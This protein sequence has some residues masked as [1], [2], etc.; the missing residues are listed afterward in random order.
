M[1]QLGL[2]TPGGRGALRFLLTAT[3]TACSG[4][5]SDTNDSGLRDG[6]APTDM[7]A[8]DDASP[9]PAPG[10]W[11][12][13]EDHYVP[14]KMAMTLV[15]PRAAD[16]APW[17]YGR[18]AHPGVRWEIPIVVQGGAWP[19]RYEIVD[20][21]GAAGLE[22][23][24]E[25]DRV[26]VDGFVVHRVTEAYGVLSWDAPVAGDY[27]IELRVTDQEGST[28]AVDVPLTVGAE[29]WLFVDAEA[30]D[31]DGDGSLEAPFASVERIHEGGDAFA[32]HRVYVRGVVP[33]DG[34]RDNGNLRI[35]T[36]TPAPAVW[37]GFPGSDAVLEAYEGKIVLDRPDFYLA[38]LEHRHRE[39]FFQAD[40]TYLHMITAWSSTDRLTLHDVHFSRFQGDGDNVGLGNST[41]IMLTDGGDAGR[42]H[43]AVVNNRL[44]GDNGLLTSA[45]Q[46]RYSVFEK[47]RA[48][49]ADFQV[50]DGS[51]WAVVYI[52][53]GN[54]EYVTLRA[55]EL[56][57]NNTWTNGRSALGILQARNVELAYNTIH[58][59]YDSGRTGAL[60]LW[61]NSPQ[62]GYSWT[63]DTPVWLYRNSLR[64]QVA[65]EGD[66]LANMPDGTVVTERNVLEEG[67]W[68]SSDRIVGVDNL[69]ED[70]FFDEEM[71]LTGAARA[72]HLGRYGAEIAVPMS[73]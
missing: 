13:P 59:P 2:S 35:A 60:Q 27:D 36:D 33:M 45:Y 10:T 34:N 55:N 21:G 64:R 39:D 54:N 23:G 31:D 7:N 29:G 38:N 40:G 67:T 70:T 41:I 73:E 61:T 53:G 48:V 58:T 37:V 69:D 17:A 16:A 49:G 19:F 22:I 6:G 51:V 18:H 57:E 8:S 66:R 71:R 50:A 47:N 3:L 5:A 4:T 62:A 28:L 63:E 25:L 42:H 56:W 52:K 26:A 32:E 20:D 72:T 1:S 43:V 46:L 12:L 15:H 65:Y 24:G 44:S 9:A 30:G 14:A 11:Q 68:P